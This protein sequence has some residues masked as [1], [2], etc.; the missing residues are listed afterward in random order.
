MFQKNVS[1]NTI[2]MEASSSEYNDRSYQIAL[3]YVNVKA[4]KFSSLYLYKIC[5]HCTIAISTTSCR[6]AMK[7]Y[8][9]FDRKKLA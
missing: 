9:R 1:Q 7:N 4:A 5:K 2:V 3:R 6:L 8:L